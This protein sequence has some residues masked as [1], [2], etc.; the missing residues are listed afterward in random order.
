MVVLVQTMKDMTT[1]DKNKIKTI[2]LIIVF[3]K[4][5]YISN[6]IEYRS[7]R[8]HFMTFK[9]NANEQSL[10]IQLYKINM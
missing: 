7:K 5:F 3:E 2:P 9:S 10:K 1:K 4:E 6:S 8:N